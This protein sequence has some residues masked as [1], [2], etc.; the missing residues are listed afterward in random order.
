LIQR[1]TRQKNCADDVAGD[2]LLNERGGGGGICGL[3][4][5]SVG[6]PTDRLSGD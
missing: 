5:H 1:L 6:G 4:A 3:I 2:N